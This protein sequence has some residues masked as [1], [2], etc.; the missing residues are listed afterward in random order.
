MSYK[1]IDIAEKLLKFAAS[2]PEGELMSN[3]K[4]QKML[5][6]QQRIFLQLRQ[7]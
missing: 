1:V 3:M 7:H 2:S 6:Y 5:Y 4:L